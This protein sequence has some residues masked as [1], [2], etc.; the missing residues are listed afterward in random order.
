MLGRSRWMIE[1]R[2]ICNTTRQPRFQQDTL[3]CHSVWRLK[4]LNEWYV[5]RPLFSSD[6]CNMTVQIARRTIWTIKIQIRQ[7]REGSTESIRSLRSFLCRRQLGGMVC[8]TVDSQSHYEMVVW[9]SG[10]QKTLSRL[11]IRWTRLIYPSW[12]QIQNDHRCYP[13]RRSTA[14]YNGW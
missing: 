12:K 7:I 4:S 2:S 11:S 3:R 14:L 8:E 5:L 13:N 10:N 6:P 9:P 1:N